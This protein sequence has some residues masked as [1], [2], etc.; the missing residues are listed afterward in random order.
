MPPE[1]KL[2]EEKSPAMFVLDK[3][4]S[5]ALL[6]AMAVYAFT[7]IW[8]WAN[9][10]F[11]VQAQATSLGETKATILE[12]QRQVTNMGTVEFR[13]NQMDAKIGRIEDKIDNLT[14]R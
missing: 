10:N 6:L 3:K 11:Q 2:E 7:V 14:T 13:L 1:P 9:M 4:I 8:A 12:V 5:M